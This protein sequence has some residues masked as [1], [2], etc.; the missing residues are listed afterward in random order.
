MPGRPLDALVPSGG[1]GQGQCAVY[2][3]QHGLLTHPPSRISI[4]V[5]W[6]RGNCLRIAFFNK[7]PPCE[8]EDEA[9][10]MISQQ[11][12]S[13]K[14]LEL[15][16][17]SAEVD[18]AEKRRLSYASAPAFALL[19][20]HKQLMMTSKDLISLDWWEHVMEFSRSISTI[21]GS[22]R[23][24][25]SPVGQNSSMLKQELLEPTL[26][27][28]IWDLLE[29][30]Y[31]DKHSLSW[32]PE[33]LVDWLANYDRVLSTTE[34][35]LHSKLVALQLKLC[36]LKIPEDDLDY[37]DGVASALAVGWL[38][39]AVTFLRM[40]GSYQLDQL[41]NRQ[42]E[43]GLV[44][45]VA[46]LI[47]KMPRMR[48][49]LPA[50]GLGQCFNLKPDFVKAWDKWRGQVAILDCSAFWNECGHHETMR[51][52]K[53][54]I[55]IMLGDIDTLASVTCHWMELLISHFLYIRPF[56]MAL[57]GMLSLSKKCIQ[58]KSPA[59]DKQLTELILGIIGDDIEVILAECSQIFD[60]WM[61]SHMI[62]LLT[63]KSF[64]AELLLH[65]EKY[66]LGGI[67]L[68]ELH[69]LVYAQ[70]LS[71]HSFTWQ[72]APIYLASCP[73]QGL[74]FLEILL[75]RQPVA[76]DNQLA[77]K[78]LEIC[79]LYELDAVG[80]SIL[81]I[82][83]MHHWKHGRKGAGIFW[84]QQ[85]RDENRLNAIAE[86]L[87]GFVGKSVSDDAFQQ[88]EGLIDLLGSENEAAGGLAFLHKDFKKALRFVQDAR[89][90]E[91]NNQKVTGAA[92][93]AVSS[94]MQLM[95]N[96]STPQQF[97]ISLLHDSVE[98]LKWPDH[99]LVNVAE[100]NLLL[101][102]LQEFSLARVRG[103]FEASK[104]DDSPQI[105]Q[106]VR[107]ALA[108]NLGRAILLE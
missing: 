41:D 7:L 59:A 60:S 99:A 4:S 14:V 51:G 27:K 108:T 48:P 46:V 97:W 100:T 95:R 93:K 25:S 83:G 53:R 47:L 5:R 65:D 20:S 91:T 62:E 75:L 12:T 10:E 87:L 32:L 55:R 22:T 107:L 90:N 76:G 21:L 80:K 52:L 92:R 56:A 67:S 94:L 42:T 72:I 86:H 70:V 104:S 71:S 63:A 29:I 98:L 105:L 39:F 26:L 81:K 16:L 74:G 103:D 69:R 44:E 9:S 13:G 73:R 96:P 6:A 85:A 102:K 89:S 61:L 1:Q 37:W 11:A 15:R 84:L 88:W 64:Q 45:A 106:Q 28:A 43:N 19:Q 34:V 2:S 82:V 3:V 58:L 49:S 17:G 8:E 30:F 66:S 40:H 35:T 68:Q 18:D 54:L 79:R 38:D 77:L 23:D 33:C 57:E 78:V 31:V 50:S 36:K 101:S 24:D